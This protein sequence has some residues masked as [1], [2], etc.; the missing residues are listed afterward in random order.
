MLNQIDSVVVQIGALI[1]GLAEERM[2]EDALL[3]ADER[4]HS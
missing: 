2:F 4:V 3:A 1:F